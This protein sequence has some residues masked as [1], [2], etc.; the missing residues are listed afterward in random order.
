MRLEFFAKDKC[1]EKILFRGWTKNGLYPFHLSINHVN[2]A[3][4]VALSLLNVSPSSPGFPVLVIHMPQYF[5]LSS[6]TFVF[7]KLERLTCTDICESPVNFGK[8]KKLPFPASTLVSTKPLNLVNIDLWGPT[9]NPSISSLR[10][11][12]CGWF[13]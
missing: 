9:P 4:P 7:L 1:S 10:Y 8:S 6:L 5:D 3:I 11:S 12:F 2:K 13:F